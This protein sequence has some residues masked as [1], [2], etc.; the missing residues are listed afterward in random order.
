MYRFIK[1]H[2][3]ISLNKLVGLQVRTSHMI[4]MPIFGKTM[5]TCAHAPK[6]AILFAVY[7]KQ[8]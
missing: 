4:S 3:L 1:P 7:L 8:A 5:L 2:F 6:D